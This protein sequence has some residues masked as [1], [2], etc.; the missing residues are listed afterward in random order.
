MRWIVL[1]DACDLRIVFYIVQRETYQC[2]ADIPEWGEVSG[3]KTTEHETIQVK[4]T[5][6]NVLRPAALK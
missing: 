3:R 1:L 2:H 6:Q 5:N 4:Y